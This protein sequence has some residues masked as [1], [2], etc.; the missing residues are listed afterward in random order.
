MTLIRAFRVFQ[1]GRLDH[2]FGGLD[3]EALVSG[4]YRTLEHNPIDIPSI[5]D[6]IVCAWPSTTTTLTIA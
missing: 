4:E 6:T 2:H 5:L 1:D 3:D